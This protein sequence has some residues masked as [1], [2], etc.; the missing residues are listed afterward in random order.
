[1]VAARKFSKKSEVSDP[2]SI[3]AA[4]AVLGISAFALRSKISRA[5]RRDTPDGEEVEL[6]L[7]VTALLPTFER[8][9]SVFVPRETAL[10]VARTKRRLGRR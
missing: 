6:A 10:I 5:P 3:E 1:M 7:G 8:K 9:W 4:A 2:L